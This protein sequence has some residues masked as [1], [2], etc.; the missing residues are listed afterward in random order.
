MNWSETD[1]IWSLQFTTLGRIH[2]YEQES[3]QMDDMKEKTS[4]LQI[5]GNSLHIKQVIL[6]M[7]DW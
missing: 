3:N 7:F 5:L 6:H 1:G 2:G 4:K